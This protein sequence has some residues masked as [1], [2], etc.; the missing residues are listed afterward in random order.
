MLR[1][2]FQKNAPIAWPLTAMMSVGA[3]LMV[4]AFLPLTPEKIDTD[5]EL[6]LEDFSN[7]SFVTLQETR[8]TPRGEIRAGQADLLTTYRFWS[9]DM[10]VASYNAWW[11]EVQ[12]L[13]MSRDGAALSPASQSLHTARFS[14]LWTVMA[15]RGIAD[16]TTAPQND[17]IAR[18]LSTDTDAF[19]EAQMLD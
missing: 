12:D 14:A 16:R 3:A 17:M 15:E 18:F 11:R 1:N 4:G 2:L 10:V 19:L 6:R 7:I 9:D 5:S 13:K 8:P